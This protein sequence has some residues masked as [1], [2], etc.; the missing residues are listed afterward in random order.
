MEIPHQQPHYSL[1]AAK[2]A[3]CLHQVSENVRQNS[4]IFIFSQ[5]SAVTEIMRDIS[6]PSSFL[7]NRRNTAVPK[8]IEIIYLLILSRRWINKTV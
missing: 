7:F 4:D 3:C 2:I 8:I 6:F 1:Q 5:T